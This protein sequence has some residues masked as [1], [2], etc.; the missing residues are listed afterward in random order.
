MKRYARI[1]KSLGEEFDRWELWLYIVIL[2]AGFIASG[3]MG[4]L[5][6]TL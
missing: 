6:G 2:P 1:K 4:W 3:M 5:I